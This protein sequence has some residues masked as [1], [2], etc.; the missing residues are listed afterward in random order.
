MT[1][2]VKQALAAPFLDAVKKA[3]EELRDASGGAIVP[4]GDTGA[5]VSRGM[6]CGTDCFELWLDGGMTRRHYATG[7]AALDIAL[8]EQA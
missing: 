3:V 8:H 6:N 7:P 1:D 4:V 5:G 2:T